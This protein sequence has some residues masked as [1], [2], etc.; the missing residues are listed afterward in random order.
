MS[1]KPV[2]PPRYFRR[3]SA[4]VIDYIKAGKRMPRRVRRERIKCIRL[5]LKRGVI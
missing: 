3:H 4:R 1:E 2:I 5:G